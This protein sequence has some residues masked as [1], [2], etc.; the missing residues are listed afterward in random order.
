MNTPS[1]AATKQAKTKNLKHC[2]KKKNTNEQKKPLEIAE[3]AIV[4]RPRP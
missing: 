4:T 1:C 3:C 2:D